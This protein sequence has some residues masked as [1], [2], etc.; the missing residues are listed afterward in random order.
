MK[1]TEIT[2]KKKQP[3]YI[4]ELRCFLIKSE[5]LNE[6]I[7][8]VTHKKYYKETLQ[9]YP[10]KTIYFLNEILGFINEVSQEEII[11]LHEWKKE[12]GGWIVKTKTENEFKPVRFKIENPG[13][14]RETGRGIKLS[15]SKKKHF[16]EVS[17]SQRFRSK[18]KK[19]LDIRFRL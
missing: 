15:K 11:Q 14:D 8:V 18:V 7:I 12:F 6:E 1:L 17:G 16:V 19:V 2:R 4:K 3:I 10:T 13:E 5:L 9:E